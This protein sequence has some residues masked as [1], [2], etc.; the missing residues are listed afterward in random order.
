MFKIINTKLGITHKSCNCRNVF[1]QFINTKKV[2]EV[3]L[4]GKI[5]AKNK[6]FELTEDCFPQQGGCM[7]DHQDV[8]FDKQDLDC[9]L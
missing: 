7:S 8:A 2:L 5:A 4:S 3:P 9:S 1:S 6:K